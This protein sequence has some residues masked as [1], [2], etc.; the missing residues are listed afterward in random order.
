M[1]IPP[2]Y[3]CLVKRY[4]LDA[5]AVTIPRRSVAAS[6]TLINASVAVKSW[7]EMRRER[8]LNNKALGGKAINALPAKESAKKAI[9]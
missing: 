2:S 5:A 4:F 8:T 3:C 9:T 1:C 7:F 6:R